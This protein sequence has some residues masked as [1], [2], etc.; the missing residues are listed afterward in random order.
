M[1]RSDIEAKGEGMIGASLHEPTCAGFAGST[2][3]ASVPELPLLPRF[4]RSTSI[5]DDH[6][7]E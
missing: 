7:L 6:A 1:I 4:R 2:S 5:K 3:V